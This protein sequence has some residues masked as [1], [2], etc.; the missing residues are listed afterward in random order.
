MRNPAEIT[1]ESAI[2]VVKVKIGLMLKDKRLSLLQRLPLEMAM[3]PDGPIEQVA[4][5]L[6]GEGLAISIDKNS[7]KHQDWLARG[8]VELESDG[9]QKS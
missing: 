7:T 1:K 4:D 6:W 5:I 8:V 2:H 3:K 9:N